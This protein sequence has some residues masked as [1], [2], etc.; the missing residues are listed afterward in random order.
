MNIAVFGSS[1]P[2]PGSP[3]YEEAYLLGK[4]LGNAG[5]T[6]WTGG[7]GGTMEAVSKG[8]SQM[9]SHV[10]G[11]TCQEIADWRGSQANPWV[12]EEFCAPTLQDRIMKMINSCDAAIALP[13]G[14]GT[15]TEIM[16]TW[17]R[18]LIEAD[19]PKPL[20]LIGSGW[21]QVIGSLFSS[22]KD[23]IL[24]AD[25]QWL[26]FAENPQ[27]AVQYLNHASKTPAD[28]IS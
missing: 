5:H 14:A 8:A 9:G 15:L 11:V 22:Q 28:S 1:K 26:S 4:L 16:L 3:D 23:H 2:H 10:I 20:I 24:P 25:K 21:E 7:Y 19:P 12:Q 6:V 18:L 13:G 27:E 17:N